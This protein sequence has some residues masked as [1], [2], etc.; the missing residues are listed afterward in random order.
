[1]PSNKDDLVKI[2]TPVKLKGIKTE[3]EKKGNKT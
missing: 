2:K 3:E 1:M